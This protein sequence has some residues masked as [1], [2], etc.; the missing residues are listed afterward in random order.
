VDSHKV[1]ATPRSSNAVV[2]WGSVMVFGPMLACAAPLAAGA[3]IGVFGDLNS[4]IHPRTTLQ[5]FLTLG[6]TCFPFAVFVFGRGAWNQMR[7]R[8]SVDWPTVMGKIERSRAEYGT[9]I[10]SG[11]YYLALS[12]RYAVGGR[13]YHGTKVFFGAPRYGRK[14]LAQ[15]L[16][17]KYPEGSD[18]TVRYEPNDPATAVLDSFDAKVW[19]DALPMILLLVAPFIVA[20]FYKC[21]DGSC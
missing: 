9:G 11:Y 4:V 2:F 20:L 17:D 12:Y 18:V 13:D 19:D 15:A 10:F 5:L 7:A 16:A 1:A 8:A 21:S 6:A 14:A 3:Y